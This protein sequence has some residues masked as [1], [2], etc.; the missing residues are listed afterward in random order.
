MKI[1]P[2]GCLRTTLKV[3]GHK[4]IAIDV[5]ELPLGKMTSEVVLDTVD[6]MNQIMYKD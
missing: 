1:S 3:S 2:K 6:S 5:L 4:A